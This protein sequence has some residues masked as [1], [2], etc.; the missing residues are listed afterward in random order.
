MESHNL[1]D[2]PRVVFS[3]R[4]YVIIAAAAAIVFGVVYFWLSSQTS[5]GTKLASKESAGGLAA[6]VSSITS[7][8][9]AAASC[10]L[11]LTALASFLGAGGVFFIMGYRTEL[12][13]AG[14]ILL[15]VSF[16]YTA[17]KINGS[18]L[19]CSTSAIRG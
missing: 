11:C 12:M 4:S 16:Y 1:L 17:R 5:Q 9:F 6:A 3:N 18:C 7:G 10:S 15:A 2:A 14:L 19:S 8:L 13:A